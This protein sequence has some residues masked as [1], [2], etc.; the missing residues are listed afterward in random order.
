MNTLLALLLV[1]LVAGALPFW[2]PLTMLV[3]QLRLLSRS[4]RKEFH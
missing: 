2:Q 3:S 1:G 4:M